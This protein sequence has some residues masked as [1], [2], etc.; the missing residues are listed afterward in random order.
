MRR[1]EIVLG[2]IQQGEHYVLQFRNGDPKIGGA[3]LVGFFGGKINHREEALLAVCREL[4]EETSLVP[5]P[6]EVRELGIV[7]VISD[8]QLEQ[9]SVLARV[10]HVPVH[11]DVDIIAQEGELVRW[12]HH[13]ALHNLHRMTPG[14]RAVFEQ[15]LTGENT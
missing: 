9:V 11:S 3:G 4:S 1:L 13:Q 6:E 7:E 14:T 2:V 10:F 12:A 5:R 15:L 8:H